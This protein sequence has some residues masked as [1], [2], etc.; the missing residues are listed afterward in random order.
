MARFIARGKNG[1]VSE[2]VC[3]EIWRVVFSVRHCAVHFH[4]KRKLAALKQSVSCGHC[5]ALT[6][7]ALT[8][9]AP[10]VNHLIQQFLS[11]PQ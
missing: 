3:S 11:K 5:T 8:M 1:N 6:T 4:K 2:V 7:K 9:P 10:G